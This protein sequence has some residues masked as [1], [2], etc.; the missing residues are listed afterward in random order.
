MKPNNDTPPEQQYNQPNAQSN[1]DSHGQ[2][3]AQPQAQPQAQSNVQPDYAAHSSLTDAEVRER[4]IS[5]GA[6]ALTD[7]QL[8]CILLQEGSSGSSSINGAK[9]GLQSG[10]A[11][12][13][14]SGSGTNPGGGVRNM[15]GGAMSLAE[16]V[17][18]DNGGNLVQLSRAGLKKLRMTEGL[19]LRRA[20][21]ITAAL[22]LGRRLALAENAEPSTIRNNEDIIRV[23]RPLLASLP[24]EEFWVV[25]LSSANTV[26]DK[27]KAGQGG[28]SGVMVDHKLIIK[29]A[30]ES[31]ASSM[32]LVHNH[33]SGVAAPSG[34]DNDLTEKIVAAAS[35]F[36][37]EVLDHLII[38]PGECFSY[39]GS[40]LL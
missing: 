34:P 8:L 10:L 25:Y 2:L 37:I 6:G 30:I 11:N 9:K 3:N 19:G 40:K 36:D 15:P 24:H 14:A 13:Y 7:A 17:L 28:V 33:P 38:T 12:G 20:A 4:L 16:R 23:F 32:I 27:V 26:I 22:E 31:L 5:R 21:A 18:S 35:L 29:R 1:V 39:R